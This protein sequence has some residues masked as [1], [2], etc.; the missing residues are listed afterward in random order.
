MTTNRERE[1]IPTTR[2]GRAAWTSF[3]EEAL[4]EQPDPVSLIRLATL[5]ALIERD[6][7]LRPASSQ[8]GTEGVRCFCVTVNNQHDHVLG[9]PGCTGTPA[10]ASP[11]VSS[12][13]KGGDASCSSPVR[14]GS[15]P[16]TAQSIQASSSVVGPIPAAPPAPAVERVTLHRIN[17]GPTWIE[18]GRASG[19]GWDCSDAEHATFIREPAG[20]GK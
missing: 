19:K 6:A 9:V 4:R 17:P 15:P 14:A 3:V 10:P 8:P 5:A 12:D 11:A 20:E 13:P 7:A 18:C 2:E 1:F 16:V